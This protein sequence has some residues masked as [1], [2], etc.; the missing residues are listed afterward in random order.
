MARVTV[1]GQ[2][3]ARPPPILRWIAPALLLVAALVLSLTS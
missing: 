2:D 1:L 3:G